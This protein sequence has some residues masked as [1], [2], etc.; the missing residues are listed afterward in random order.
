[1]FSKRE[2]K[3]N[4]KIKV[5]DKVF[6]GMNIRELVTRLGAGLDSAGVGISPTPPIFKK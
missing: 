2:K 3:F 4:R 5:R 6:S 1:M